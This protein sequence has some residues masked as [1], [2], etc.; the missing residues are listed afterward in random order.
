MI[1]PFE[2]RAGFHTGGRV[3]IEY[4]DSKKRLVKFVAIDAIYRYGSSTRYTYERTYSINTIRPHPNRY[5]DKT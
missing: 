5:N 3:G 2:N 1:Q 4:R